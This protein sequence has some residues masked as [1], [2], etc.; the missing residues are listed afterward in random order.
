MNF[1]VIPFLSLNGQAANAIAFYEQNL[2]ARVLFK[3]TYEQMAKMD[4]DFHYQE[5]EAHYIVHSV[6][7]IG[8][9]KIMLAEENSEQNKEWQRANHFSLCLQAQEKET[10][11]T[12][13]R[14]IIQHKGTTIIEPLHANSFSSGY[15]IVKD[16]FGIIFQLTVTRHNF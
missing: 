4:P 13:Y 14:N 10:I 15:A 11:E 7:E 5:G 2:N 1:E 8:Q 9:N 6:L 16:P 3:V 12:L